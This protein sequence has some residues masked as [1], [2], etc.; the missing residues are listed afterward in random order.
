MTPFARFSLALVTLAIAGCPGPTPPPPDGGRDASTPD[1]PL[2]DVP[3]PLDVPMP[4][5]APADVPLGD[6]GPSCGNGALDAGEDCDGTALGTA[7][8]ASEGFTAGT[9]GCNADCTFDTSACTECGNGT[10]EDGE[11][12]DGTD[13]GGATCMGAGFD[14]GTLSCTATC[15]LD[16]SACTGEGCGDG[17]ING[18]ELC[19][20]ADV[21]V[22]SCATE[23]FDGGT[24]GCNATCDAFVTTACTY[25]CGDGGID[26]GETC[27]GAALGGATCMGEGFVSGSI[28]CSS[29]CTLDTSGCST[30][31]DGAINGS[32]VCDGTALG[33]ATCTSVPGGFTAGTLACA[34]G[35]AAFDTSACTR[36]GN[37]MIEGSEACD[38]AALGGASCTSLGLGFMSGTLGCQM[39]CGAYDTSRCSSAR[40]PTPGE[41]V[42]TEFMPNPSAVGD[43]GGE[44]FEITSDASEPISLDGCVVSDNQATPATFTITGGFL[45]NPGAYATFA[46]G[47][48]PGFTPDY[49]YSSWPL[50]NVSGSSTDAIIITCGGV[51]ID[52]VVYSSAFPWSDGGSASLDPGDTS[53]AANDVAANYCD[54]S[55]SYGTGAMPDLGSPGMA[56]PVCPFE[57]CT[58]GMDEDGD[59]LTDCADTADCAAAPACVPLTIDFCRLHF[60][61]TAMAAGGGAVGPVYGRVYVGGLTDRT[62]GNDLDTRLVAAVGYGADGSSPA[63]GGWTWTAAAP[64]AGYPGP[65]AE[66][67]NDEYQ[68]TFTAPSAA[69]SYDYAFRFSGDGG[70]TWTYCDTNAGAGSDGSQDGYQPANAGALTVTAASSCHLTINEVSVAGATAG[71]E[72]VEIYNGCAAAV[73]V[74]GWTL[75]YRSATGTSDTALAALTGSIPAGGYRLYGGMGYVPGPAVDGTFT[76]GGPTGAL[77]GAG[78]GVALRSGPIGTG[79]IVDSVGYGT[80]TNAFV[81]GAVAMAPAANMAI[82]RQPDGDDT[83]SNAADFA[84]TARTPRAANP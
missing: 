43:T 52:R 20:G 26:P 45:L 71:D 8:C 65:G 2:L 82:S 55:T 59:G 54:A 69:G 62:T 49:V 72:Y 27:D 53:A 80:A 30:C 51:E 33:G 73:D 61:T 21:G 12:C 6:G 7:T 22:A 57:V 41:I 10:L 68:A 46:N 5:D 56:N 48:A 77:A 58:G 1:V 50:A 79:A 17:T 15:T 39:D 37:G 81:E 83:G 28:A 35:C 60:P 75:V 84:V 11:S 19:D 44:W 32:D 63:G 66:A 70:T 24:L 16:T 67:N 18:T 36:C 64:N 40:V 9:L 31:G 76:S 25:T 23:G 4:I 78:G 13:L 29:T 74:T 47:P 34:P 14:G 42:I 38:G 3:T